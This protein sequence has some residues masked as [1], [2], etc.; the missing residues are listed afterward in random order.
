MK[1][2][3][4]ERE[5]SK[6]EQMALQM[7][8]PRACVEEADAGHKRTMSQTDYWRE[9]N[10]KRWCRNLQREAGAKQLYEVLARAGRFDLDLL[11]RTV[12]E[13]ETDKCEEDGHPPRE[14]DEARRRRALPIAKAEARARCMEGRL[15][16]RHRAARRQQC[17]S[18]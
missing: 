8:D 10:R 5:N 15:A 14:T 17:F 13:S 9:Q 1:R 16:A 11:L 18:A 6:K 2:A 7:R 12:A 3:R 4:E